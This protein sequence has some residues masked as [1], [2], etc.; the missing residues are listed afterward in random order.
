MSVNGELTLGENIGDLGGLNFAYTAYKN[1]LGGKPAETIEGLTGDQR[2]FLGWGQVW[3]RLYREPE[4][5]RRLLD[6]P[7]SPSQYRVN[8]IVSNMDAFYDAFEI[9]PGDAM[10]IAPEK[11]VRIW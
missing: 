8:G 7:H 9:K 10:Y 5:R 3:R 1:S 2:F 11:R 6:D 4:L